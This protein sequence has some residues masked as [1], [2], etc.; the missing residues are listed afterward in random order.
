ML[1]S[2]NQA[3]LS[4]GDTLLFSKLSFHV[5]EGDCVGVIGRNGVG[6]SSL[7]RVLSGDSK[8]E[9][10]TVSRKKGLRL[11][12]VD[13]VPR[14]DPSLS[15]E[16]V[17]RQHLA[18]LSETMPMTETEQQVKAQMALSKLGF[19]DPKKPV[20]ELSG[21][22]I[23]R[24]ALAV[25][26]S[27]EP[28]L[29]LLDEPTNHLDLEGI[30]WLEQWLAQSRLSCV[31]ITHDRAFL[32]ACCTKIVELNPAYPDGLLQSEGGY[33][34]FLE[35][36]EELQ[37]TQSR[38]ME[39][40]ENRVRNELEWLKQGPKARASKDKLHTELVYQLMDELDEMKRLATTHEAQIDFNAS[41]RKTKRLL[42][43]R[44]LGKSRGGKTLFKD[45]NL[46]LKPGLRLGLAGGN[47]TGKT[48]LLRILADE[49]EPDT[50]EMKTAPALQTVVFDQHR[51]SLDPQDTL[52][53][54]LR[55]DG[56]SVMV[57]G[58][59]VHVSG[60]AKRFGFDS[61][62]LVVPVRQLSGGE[63]AKVLIARLMTQEADVLLLDEPTNDLDLPTLEILEQNLKEFP[64]ALV[65][66]THDRYML[67]QVCNV[68]LGL[69]GQGGHALVAD[70]NQW[71]T[72]K[73]SLEK[74]QT[75]A[76]K[77]KAKAK[78]KAEKKATKLSY[79][80]QREYDGLEERILEAEETLSEA[81][82][83][84]Q[85]PSIM[86]D[87]EQ[88]RNAAQAY[89]DAQ[90]KVDALY[91]RWEELEAKQSGDS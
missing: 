9:A 67:D 81:E 85:D 27:S 45:L 34:R 56:D 78:P 38:A 5:S 24:V 46:L 19:L 57:R 22:W 65:L 87:P 20:G 54:A 83:A 33:V 40:M 91:A 25:A 59:P 48:T 82:T 76:D 7:L 74:E 14:F 53:E 2:I 84:L 35:R 80:D 51:E 39:T 16:D 55:P 79:M 58:R 11:A 88:S 60:W 23:K 30:F 21:G 71:M 90:D 75:K 61:R 18:I 86:A 1:C 37:A 50:G 66:V 31:L 4:Y 15:V 73:K 77:P 62:Q 28:E 69:D 26:I 10:G 13:Q 29:L 6:K 17:V 42:E 32:E 8:P 70:Y 47:G 63:Q 72:H 68:I 64:G 89:Q 41:G 43:V 36:R 49:L 52:K 44:G 3:R 12:V